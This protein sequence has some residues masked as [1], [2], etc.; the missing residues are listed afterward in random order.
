MP[1]GIKKGM[2]E[3]REKDRGGARENYKHGLVSRNVLILAVF[4]SCRRTL[5][6]R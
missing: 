2:R 1:Q 4:V 3:E 6:M 5:S